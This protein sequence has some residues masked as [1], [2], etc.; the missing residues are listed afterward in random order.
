MYTKKIAHTFVQSY[1]IAASRYNYK[2]RDR[3]LPKIFPLTEPQL[4][5]KM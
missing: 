1:F 5:I 4:V 3:D 2:Q